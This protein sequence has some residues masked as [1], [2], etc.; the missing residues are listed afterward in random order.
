MEMCILGEE[1]RTLDEYDVHVYICIYTSRV[2]LLILATIFNNYYEGTKLLLF[3]LHNAFLKILSRSD[4]LFTY[5]DEAR[6]K[7]T[8]MKTRWSKIYTCILYQ[9]LFV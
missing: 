3:S 6:T 4:F 5:E 7:F 1:S 9:F 8:D 2:C